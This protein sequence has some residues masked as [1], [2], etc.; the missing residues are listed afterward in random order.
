MMANESLQEEESGVL[1][2]HAPHAGASNLIKQTVSSMR[3][4]GPIK[5]GSFNTPFLSMDESYRP[6][7]QR[8]MRADPHRR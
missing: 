5:K 2:L 1:N 7:Q 4:G 8:N 6:S 3:W